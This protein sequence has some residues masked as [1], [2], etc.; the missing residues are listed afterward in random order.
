[1]ARLCL[2][3]SSVSAAFTLNKR[4]LWSVW[5]L[6]PSVMNHQ[7]RLVWGPSMK[8]LF[9]LTS[10][11]RNSEMQRRS[12]QEWW[13]LCAGAAPKLSLSNERETVANPDESLNKQRKR[14]NRDIR[15]SLKESSIF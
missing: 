3:F 2:C 10:Q 1:M 6:Q 8:R 9:F 14:R 13:C 5:P 7:G 12:F 11:E 4:P 15:L